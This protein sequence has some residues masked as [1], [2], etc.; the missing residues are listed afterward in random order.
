M[1][2]PVANWTLSTETLLTR[3]SQIATATNNTALI[4]GRAVTGIGGAGLYCGTY[5]IIA[6]IVPAAKRARY[7]GLV[8]VSYAVASVAGPLIGGVFTD[9]ISWRWW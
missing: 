8:G 1:V 9:N 3:A 2:G 5:T 4:V 6:F 7:T